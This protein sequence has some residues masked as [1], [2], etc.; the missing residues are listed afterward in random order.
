MT[1]DTLKYFSQL[2]IHINEAYGMSE[3]TGVT[4]WSTN[5][6]HAWGTVGSALPGME[7]KIFKRGTLEEC[8]RA[9]VDLNHIP[10]VCMGEV[11]FRGRHVMMG[12]MSNPMLGAKHVDDV[13]KK[14][15]EAID[16]QGWLHSG[17]MGVKTFQ[18][19]RLYYCVKKKTNTTCLLDGENYR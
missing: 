10:E 5:E 3:N 8:P 16:S 15:E 4:T 13:R 2:G 12:Y 17:D 19:V 14:N 1:V 18:G 6:V 7:V 11:C 9:P